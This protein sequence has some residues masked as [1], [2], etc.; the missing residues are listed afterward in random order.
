MT[1]ARRALLR[2]GTGLAMVAIAG[3]VQAP[4]ADRSPT[5]PPD[6]ETASTA[7]PTST[8][9]AGGTEEVVVELTDEL[10]F[11]PEA[12]TVTTGSTVVWRNVG[13]VSHTVTAYEG[14]I[15]GG[16]GYFASGGFE[17]ESAAR[18]G[19]PEGEITEGGSYSHTFDTTGEYRYF[20][21]P[22]EQAGMI[23]TVTVE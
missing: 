3:C 6:S 7:P 1:I 23:G 2:R 4:D 18:D 19:F 11:V 12:L 21:I 14:D 16:A 5:N 15:P 20:C 17:T 8:D 10:T 9:R 22:H 13:S